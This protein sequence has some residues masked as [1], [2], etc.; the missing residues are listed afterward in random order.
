MLRAVSIL[1]SVQRENVAEVASKVRR[2]FALSEIL[3]IWF[4][5][6]IIEQRRPYCRFRWSLCVIGS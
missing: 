6:L 1:C 5:L 2:S 3:E 4:G